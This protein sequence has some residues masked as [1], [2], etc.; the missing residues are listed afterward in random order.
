M[1]SNGARSRLGSWSPRMEVK[2]L[3]ED[4]SSSVRPRDQK[5]EAQRR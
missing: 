3:E 5:L 1:G 2:Q 4:S